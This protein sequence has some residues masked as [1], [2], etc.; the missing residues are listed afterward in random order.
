MLLLANPKIVIK[1]E[2]KKKLNRAGSKVV[3]FLKRKD[4]SGENE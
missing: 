2:R 1:K 4:G 3:E